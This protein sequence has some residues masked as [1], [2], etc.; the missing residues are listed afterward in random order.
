[1][2]PILDNIG[3]LG[4]ELE[5]S[6]QNPPQTNGGTMSNNKRTVSVEDEVSPIFR[7]S[8]AQPS[9]SICTSNARFTSS[10]TYVIISST[11]IAAQQGPS[12]STNSS[13]TPR[14]RLSYN[15]NNSRAGQNTRKKGKGAL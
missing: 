11:S 8:T 6:Q 9:P 5:N 14:F 2:R 10:V 7:R 4:R 1:M 13:L 12:N 15:F 3:R